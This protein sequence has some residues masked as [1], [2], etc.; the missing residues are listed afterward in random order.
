MKLFR[1]IRLFLLLLTAIAFLSPPAQAQL[2]AK[3]SLWF[4]PPNPPRQLRASAVSLFEIDLSWTDTSGNEDGFK[5]ERSTDGIHFT[6]IAQVLANTSTFRNT[7]LFPNTRYWYRVRA[8]NT[9]GNSWFLNVAQTKTQS[10]SCD[11]SLNDFGSGIYPAPRGVRNI[12]AIS[13]AGSHSVALKSDGSVLAWG[14]N[15]WGEATAPED[16]REVV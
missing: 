5:I 8:F 3:R 1:G 9:A 6:Q 2:F 16:L 14:D 4:F 15:T 11:L 10:P 7:G 12:V 13:T